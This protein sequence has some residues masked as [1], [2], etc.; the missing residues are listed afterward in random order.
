MKIAVYCGS[1]AGNKSVFT[2]RAGQLGKKMAENGHTLVYGG[3]KTGMMGAIADAVLANKGKVIGVVPDVPVIKERTHPG[4]TECIYTDTMA[5][6]KSRMI[7]LADAFVAMPGGIGT[8]DEITEV[9]SLSSLGIVNGAIVFLN[10]EGYYDGVKE[11]LKNVVFNGYGRPEYFERILFSDDPQ[12]I[13]EFIE[14]CG[15]AKEQEEKE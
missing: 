3:S 12:E 4:L 5:E 7:D 8:L 2:E 14:R 13:V 15:N 11:L 9:I 1:S 6:R 10:T